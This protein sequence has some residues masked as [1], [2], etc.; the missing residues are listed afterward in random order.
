VSL[1][2]RYVVV[3]LAHARASW[4]G[5]VARWATTGAVPVEFVQCLSVEELRA[6]L[7]SG[8]PFSAVLLDGAVPGVD[9]DVADLARRAGCAVLVVDDGR[10]ERDWLGLGASDVLAPPLAPA[11]L[12]DALRAHATPIATGAVEGWSPPPADVGWLGA[13]VAVTGVPGAGVSTVAAALSQGLGDDPRNAGSVVLADLALDAQQAVLHDASDIVPGLPELVDAHRLGNPSPDEVRA[14]TFGVTGRGY[15]LLLGLRRHRDWAALRPRAVEAALDGLRRSFRLTV[16]DVSA[17]L[18]GE[19]QCGSADVEDRNVLART[20]TASAS[21]VVVAGRPGPTG[22]HRLLRIVDALLEHGV[23]ATAIVTVVNRAP[24]GPRARAEITRAFA[25][26]ARASP[27][28]ARLAAPMFLPERRRLDDLI[29]DGHRL[30][31]ALAAPVTAAA[32]AFLGVA[33]GSGR[34]RSSSAAVPVAVAP[35]SVPT[36][37]D[38]DR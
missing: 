34:M 10:A 5:D 36:W 1:G 19:A 4:F 20:A 9:R 33:D 38:P 32:V 7:G 8:R 14:L 27:G 2:D 37:T 35:G 13:L 25:D 29:G 16:A 3:G 12:R 18:E 17:D 21:V 22:I 26:L 28:G 11:R 24:R 30:P 31:A 6:R 15:R 23:P